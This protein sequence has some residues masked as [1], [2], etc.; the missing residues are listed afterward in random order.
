MGGPFANKKSLF[1]IPEK[2]SYLNC[3]YMSPLS[4]KV[5]AAGHKAMYQKARPYEIGSSD[6]FEPVEELK[7]EYSK[8]IGVD[9]PHRITIIPSASYGFSTVTKNL[10]IS[11]GQNIVILEEQF[12]SNVYCWQRLCRDKSSKIRGQIGA[13]ESLSQ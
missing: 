6:F 5:L 12:P 11:A 1:C 4:K 9:N 10:S 2:V 3:A 13:T 8:L 7:K